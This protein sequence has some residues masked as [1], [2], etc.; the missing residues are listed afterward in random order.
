MVY[1]AHLLVDLLQDLG[2]LLEAEDDVLLDLRELDARRQLLE[3]LQLR[4][5]LGQQRLL[6]LLA[7]QRQQ[8]LLLVALG[9]HLLRDGRLAVCQAGDVALVVV[10]LIALDLEVQDGPALA[11]SVPA[12]RRTGPGAPSPPVLGRNPTRS[13]SHGVVCQALRWECIGQSFEVAGV[14]SRAIK[15]GAECPVWLV[16][17]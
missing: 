17:Q 10:Q 8:R 6:V 15:V 1:A 3:L 13:I 2:A 9:E 12:P 4:V 11:V 14:Y 7:P 16:E 5:R